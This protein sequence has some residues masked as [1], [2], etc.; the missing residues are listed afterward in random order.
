[1]EDEATNTWNPE[2]EFLYA[3]DTGYM[4]TPPQCRPDLPGPGLLG[5]WLVIK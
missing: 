4:Q 5:T 2:L 3:T 1:M